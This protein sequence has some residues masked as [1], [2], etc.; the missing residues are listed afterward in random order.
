MF[1]VTNWINMHANVWVPHG[2][3]VLTNLTTVCAKGNV[4][5]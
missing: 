2:M 4:Y 5:F 1:V 3:H